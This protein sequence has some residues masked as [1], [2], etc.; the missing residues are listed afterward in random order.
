MKS[1][2][3]LLLSLALIFLAALALLKGPEIRGHHTNYLTP[4]GFG[5]HHPE[6]VTHEITDVVAFSPDGTLLASGGG[7]EVALW[8]RRTRRVVAVLRGPESIRGGGDIAFSPDGR[9]LASACDDGT[10]VIWDVASRA[11][12]VVIKVP[13][14]ETGY[15][16]LAWS[17]SSD[18][19]I[20]SLAG[21]STQV[22]SVPSGSLVRALAQ[23]ESGTHAVAWSPDGRWLALGSEGGLLVWDW[24][25]GRVVHTSSGGAVEELDFTPDGKWL[26][27]G[28]SLHQ[29]ES[30]S[31]T[32]RSLALPTFAVTRSAA[33]GS[34]MKMLR[35]RSTVLLQEGPG[36]LAEWNP[37]TRRASVLPPLPAGNLLALSPDDSEVVL[38]G[39]SPGRLSFCNLATGKLLPPYEGQQDPMRDLRFLGSPHRLA[40]ST[41]RALMA[42]DVARESSFVRLPWDRESTRGQFTADGRLVALVH[43]WGP[44]EVWNFEQARRI[45][46][47]PE[48]STEPVEVWAIQWTGVDSSRPLLTVGMTKSYNASGRVLRW[49]PLTGS[50]EVVWTGPGPVRFLHP[51]GSSA[52]I[53]HVVEGRQALVDLATGRKIRDLPDAVRAEFSPDGR[54]LALGTSRSVSL[55]TG[56]EAL[57]GPVLGKA[58]DVTCLAF[59]PDSRLVASVDAHSVRVWDLAARSVPSS[60]SGV[61]ASGPSGTLAP[62]PRPSPSLTVS[63]AG[64]PVESTPLTVIDVGELR[65]HEAVFSPDGK[66][67][68]V[69][70][71]ENAVR[72]YDV[73]TGARLGT[74]SFL[75]N[76][77]RWFFI[78][79]D[80]RYDGSDDILDG[81]EVLVDGR[82]HPLVAFDAR[83]HVPGLL[84]SILRGER[85][86]APRELLALPSTTP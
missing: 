41:S 28:W 18:K 68:L 60:A 76:T 1:T 67:L 43:H 39:E 80:G 85:P 37:M 24:R 8:S 47:L 49:D 34:R 72:V 75:F 77:T 44:V 11:H 21:G 33:V 17:S 56:P 22:W 29:G 30:R 9:W 14:D 31:F 50:R 66:T 35:T 54:I 51:Q 84:A 5:A 57:P 13:W 52:V 7:S 3:V 86:P 58:F 64:S 20:S 78:T 26:V 46:V 69:K 79:P 82:I 74:M 71:E 27:A 38:E 15:I 59:S 10:V 65:L 32:L 81:L 42:T 83:Y 70:G 55:W 23:G 73:A 45:A 53:Y 19:L 63:A 40:W 6:L 61:S 25:A 4:R 62:L 36:R 16:Q 48:S 12:R 2:R